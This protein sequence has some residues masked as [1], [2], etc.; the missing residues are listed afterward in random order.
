[1]T[2]QEERGSR[3]ND[4]DRAEVQVDEQVVGEHVGVRRPSATM[5]SSSLRIGGILGAGVLIA[6][7][8]LVVLASRGPGDPVDSPDPGASSVAV[9]SEPVAGASPSTGPSPST[10]PTPSADP[11]VEPTPRPTVVATQAPEPTEWPDWPIARDGDVLASVAPGDAEDIHWFTC[12][13]SPCDFD[14]QVEVVSQCLEDPDTALVT[15]RISW[16]GDLPVD[17]FTGDIGIDYRE[18]T[19]ENELGADG[20]FELVGSY[21][22]TVNVRVGRVLELHLKVFRENDPSRPDEDDSGFLMAELGGA[23]MFGPDNSCP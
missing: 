14:A 22:R 20:R 21:D 17:R 12:T 10:A 11:T 13:A 4:S 19:T 8:A 9:A 7:G 5:R 3:T 1:V 18:A 6:A 23:A 2:D 16:D 15:F